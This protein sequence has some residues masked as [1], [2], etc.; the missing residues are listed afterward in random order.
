MKQTIIQHREQLALARQQ[1]LDLRRNRDRLATG[2]QT[3]KATDW[4]GMH[5]ACVHLQ[6]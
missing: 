2:A 3:P 4:R 6:T 1:S 5:R